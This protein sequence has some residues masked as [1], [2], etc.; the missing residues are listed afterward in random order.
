M[1]SSILLIEDERIVAENLANILKG[2]GYSEVA[3]ASSRKEAI[4][5]YGSQEVC[6][7]IS[8]VNLF[9]SHEGPKIVKE[10][11]S[12]NPVPVIYLTAYS[13]Q[14]T[15]EDALETAP[16]AYVLKPFTERQLLVAVKM[17]LGG[18][19]SSTLPGQVQK[20]SGRELEIIQ[21][22]AEGNNSKEI[23]EKLF[24][25]EHTVRTH[26]RNLLKKLEIGSSS[27][28]IAI[29]IKLKWIRP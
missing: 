8:D 29:A 1:S 7:I 4:A 17:A 23:A 13:D 10:L 21:C 20:P 19:V 28:L 16:A 11:L 22:L 25:S 2:A 15:L 24:I 12:F 14:Q 9:G 18:N 5:L 27:E 26:R 3:I 6:L